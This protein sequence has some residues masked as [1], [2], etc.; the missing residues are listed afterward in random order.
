MT[1]D[2]HPKI[3]I[4]V[5]GRE[6]LTVELA[7][8]RYGMTPNAM[9]VRLTRLSKQP[10]HGDD[11]LKPIALLDSRKPLYLA[12]TLDRLMRSLPGKGSPG[13]PRGPR[14]RKPPKTA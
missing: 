13:Q 14:P 3:R 8:A 2:P 9:G 10:A 7:A 4:T 11:P 5:G 6:A 12:T 1:E